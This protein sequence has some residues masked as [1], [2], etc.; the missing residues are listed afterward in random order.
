MEESTE[1][2]AVGADGSQ[3]RLIVDA[4]PVDTFTYGFYA[5][6]SPD[7]TRIVYAT[8]E[9][10]TENIPLASYDTERRK[11]HYEI[12]VINLDGHRAAAAHGE[13][14]P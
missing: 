1:I 12:A 6:V 3:L 10:L 8:C 13:H 11:Y 9:F 4:N 2:W 5:N 7:G 14:A